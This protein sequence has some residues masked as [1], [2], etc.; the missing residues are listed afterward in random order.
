MKRILS[1][2]IIMM[3]SISITTYG[4]TINT[5]T[6][7]SSSDDY[8]RAIIADA[9][10]NI[11][12]SGGFSGTLDF[13]PSAAVNSLT[14]AGS[15]DLFIAKYTPNFTLI[16]VKR[17]GGSGWDEGIALSF[18]NSG[19]LLLSGRYVGTVDVDPNAG[20]TNVS[21]VGGADMLFGE[22][23]TSGN[24]VWC[25]S[26]GSTDA[27]GDQDQ[28]N[29]IKTNSS[30]EIFIC[31]TFDVGTMDADPGAGI[32]SHT[33][34]SSYGAGN[35][36]YA[37]YTSTGNYIFSKNLSGCCDAATGLVVDANGD[38]ILTGGF[39][40]GLDF[41]PDAGYQYL[42][43]AYYGDIWLAK[44]NGN[45]GAY[46]WAKSIYGPNQGDWSNAIASD[47]Q[48]NIYIT[49]EFS[50]TTDFD[51]DA[52]VFNLT[53]VDLYDGYIAK[54]NS[55][56]NFIWAKA[57]SGSSL[58]DIRSISVKGGRLAV[59]G[60]F[61][62]TTD[63]DPSAA[64][65]NL[66][67]SGNGDAFVALYDTSGA[68]ITAEKAGGSN[69]EDA[70]SVV[71]LDNNTVVVAGQSNSTSYNIGGN[72]NNN[73]GAYDAFISK[74]SLCSG[75]PATI[76]SISPAAANVGSTLVITGTNFETT[77][78][79]NTVYFGGVKGVV[80]AATSSSLSVTVPSGAL[81]DYITLSNSCG[82]V[83][84]SLQ[85]FNPTFT[86]GGNTATFNSSI[87]YTK[88]T[89]VFIADLDGDGKNDYIQSNDSTGPYASTMTYRLNT[90]IVPGTLSLASPQNI[91]TGYQPLSME[92]G[93]I[94]G[95]GKAD[96]LVIGG[97]NAELLIYK[98]TSTPGNVNFA[99]PINVGTYFSVAQMGLADIDGDG[100]LDIVMS[101]A[102]SYPSALI[103]HRNLSNIGNISLAAYQSIYSGTTVIQDMKIADMD[104]DSK[105]DI[106]VA[107]NSG[108]R[109][110]L[111][112]SIS[113]TINFAA[114]YTFASTAYND[115][116]Q[117]DVADLDGD[118][119]IDIALP[120]ISNQQAALYRNTSSLGSLSFA[121]P[122]NQNVSDY[123]GVHTLSCADLNGDGKP[124]LLSGGS[125]I[126]TFV[127]TSTSGNFSFGNASQ[128]STLNL[129]LCIKIGDLNLDQKPD[130]LASNY[131]SATQLF[132]NTSLSIVTPTVSISASL[133]SICANTYVTFTANATN[134]GT[135]PSYNFSVN[136]ISTL[137][138]N[139][140]TFTT[141]SLANG[142]IVTCQ[143]SSSASCL[144]SP[145]ANSNSISM[146][147]HLPT[148]SNTP[149]TALGSYTWNGNTYSSSGFYSYST[150]NQYGCDSFA[151][152]N[153]TIL[154]ATV[155][156]S[157]TAIL[158]GYYCASC[159]SMVSVLYNQGI[160]PSQSNHVDS[161]IVELHNGT[162]PFAL[163][164]SYKG[165][166][167][168][169]GNI[170]CTF[171][172]YALGGNY[173]IVLKHRNSIETWSA[174]A[175]Y[176]GNFTSYN[177]SSAAFLAYGSNMKQIDSSPDIKWAI[178][179]GDMNQDGYIDGFDYPAFDTDSQNNV[180]GVYVATDL[181]GDGYV[182]GFDY[183]LFDANSQNTV[184]II[185][186]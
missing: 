55:N 4:N 180:S 178:Y 140:N 11:Y 82:M 74:V 106:V 30:G 109:I 90:N 18:T 137:V 45:T 33:N 184:S 161:V 41:D 132:I 64:T 1:V 92:F 104:G 69:Y 7:G 32:A 73:A 89:R 133:N 117:F 135:T 115:L 91:I 29:A 179:S 65:F 143:L 63:F 93:D 17:I 151:F 162:F 26:I 122:F 76:T 75:N 172:G 116:R 186:P 94:D 171:P 28:I 61:Y 60:Y 87:S 121:T 182:D 67:N 3:L 84:K 38:F 174:T 22:Y 118:G 78:S 57:L 62:N 79:N 170:N 176:I 48:G 120:M 8:N 185:K 139:L 164:Y 58:A 71:L 158:E 37:K 108:G 165:I 175:A 43:A 113:G 123:Y 98:N 80:T 49:G 34:F 155:T 130:I 183:P 159:D 169:N 14:S 160:E 20:I 6:L 157:V 42:G 166:M 181:N 134:T 25:K 31:G 129:P 149:V 173:Y 35:I 46:M 154:P 95:D 77:A 9:S 136:G 19:N 12:V 56:G 52:G 110:F 131:Y 145:L 54:Y 125:S 70:F 40:G 111:N 2:C 83:C 114:P 156:V 24:L 101:R 128:A 27:T 85:K 51:M 152:I 107:D 168:S 100:K 88:S 99:A 112:G 138:T 146:I 142:D 150:T 39:Q 124:D 153:L 127:N 72:T 167:N 105:V 177:F 141:N 96:L 97:Y 10:G 59:C 126:Y 44:Y 15:V 50:P 81:Y 53:G 103:V 163:A 148:Y 23:T 16:W 68:F 144:T 5:I 47:A 147:V 21:S 13:D 66:T 36:F 119:K 86:C 102:R